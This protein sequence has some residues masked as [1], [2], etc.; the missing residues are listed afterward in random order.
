[1][2]RVA[3]SSNRH[4]HL[5]PNHR[6]GSSS[7]SWTIFSGRAIGDSRG[8]A[9]LEPRTFAILGS[10]W[11]RTL[12]RVLWMGCSLGVILYSVAVLTHVAWMGSIGVRCL[13]GTKVE[14]EIPAD[15]A[16]QE[17]RPQIGDSLL[18]I[19][20]YRD[21]RREL[22]GLHP[23]AARLERPGR[24]YHRGALA[25]SVYGD[26]SFG[27]GDGPVS[28]VVDLLSGRASGFSRSC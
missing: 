7:T 23:D 8:A 16:W 3:P 17:S 28:A 24:R 20:A 18:S 25:R 14:E 21:S 13:F 26:G 10:S 27:P 1:M 15:Y 4:M 22:F 9:R 11:R 2:A 5:P 6:S 19:G 12:L